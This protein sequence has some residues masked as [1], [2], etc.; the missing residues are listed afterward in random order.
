MVNNSILDEPIEEINVPVMK[1]IPYVAKVASLRNLTR[2]YVESLVRKS[3]ADVRKT[4]NKFADWI[5]SHVPERVRRN[6]N[7]RVEKLKK[8][9]KRI[10]SRYGEHTLYEREAPLRG[11]LRTYR[12]DGRRGYDQTTF[13]QYI[14]PRVIKLLSEKK[15]PFQVKFI[16]TFKFL[17]GEEYNES[18]FHTNVERIMEGTNI[19]DLYNIMIAMCLEKI[20]KFQNKGSGWQFDSVV[21]FDI[22]VDPFNPIRGSLYF[23]LPEKLARKHA[24]INVQNKQDN[25][26]FKWAVTS[27]V[28]QRKVHPE[29]FNQELIDNSKRLNWSGIDFPTPLNQIEIFEQQN[30]YSI[31]VYGYRNES[32]YTLRISKKHE[33]GKQ[34]IKLMLLE[35]RNNNHYCWIKDG[36]RLISSQVSKHNG[37]IYICDYCDNTFPTEESFER[38]IEYCSKHKAV[39]VNMPEKGTMLS[40]KNHQRKM[41]VPFVVYADFEALTKGISTCSPNDTSSYTKQYQKHTPCSFSYYIKCFD[42][43]L[44]P[45]QLRQYTIKER[46][47]NVGKIFVDNL[48]KDI[49]EIYCKFKFK[50]NMRITTEEE[51]DFQKATVCHICENLL[52]LDKVRDH[53]HLTGK[54][55]GAAHNQCNLNHVIPS[56]Y[57]VIFHNLSGYDTH[58]FIKDLAETPGDIKCIAKTEENYISFDKTLI[59]DTFMKNGKVIKVKRRIRFL[60][61]FRFMQKSLSELANN[62]TSN[63]NLQKHFDTDKLELVK[64][65]GVYP[66]D[67]MD[68]FERLSETSLPPIECW[69]SK[70]N[71]TNISTEEYIHAQ[72]VW[73][74]FGMKTMRDYHDLYLK[75][76]V[77]LLTDV[78]EEF[79]YLCSKH[80]GLDPAWYYTSPGLAWDA[81]LKM[82]KVE[83]ELLHDQDMLLLIEEA[84]RGG[85]SMISTRLGKANHKFMEEYDPSQP[86]KY[87]AY[88]DANNLYG[89]AMS[90]KLPTHGFKWMTPWQLVNW[91]YH[92][93]IVEVD[94]EYPHDLHDLHNDY[95]LAPE[96]LKMDGVDKL[97]PN[98]YNKSKY[99]VH[100]E[101]LKLYE[102]LGLVIT[103]VYKG[104]VFHDSNWM[105]SYIDINTKLRIQSKNN[106]EKDFFKLMNNSVFGKTIEDVRTRTDIKLV[107]TKEQA[108]KYI[109]K[110]NYVHRTT[111][112]DNLVAIHMEKTEIYMNKPVYLGMS[113]LDIS[114]TLMYEFHY[115]YIKPKYGD[116][117][118]LLFTDTD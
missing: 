94:L 73:D 5:I 57:P 86:S 64:R 115:N 80:Y 34:C 14:R 83:L 99:V 107:T 118:K 45:P 113:I 4:I 100:Y 24:I 26:C 8:D 51:Q 33:K 92:T 75:T 37:K 36:S 56:F 116:K 59:V 72:R 29:R 12:I 101:T 42:D 93:C 10:Y 21:S 52:L 28:F 31:N 54:Y 103:K 39:K 11:F 22:N 13:T 58:M 17:K 69:Y 1:P 44:F 95:P 82:T 6:A 109:Y 76:D 43:E 35:N 41:R 108:E 48:E 112:S 84:I 87:I 70:L 91:R 74:V 98:L 90:K 62:L 61:S 102:R 104:I 65:K 77:L 105:K 79:R 25:K 110:P 114:K 89:W 2:N 96:H 7:E 68:S 46:G 85:V 47:E 27:A 9:I 63:S 32:V 78:F 50:K 30:P 38:H 66:Y 19:G 3:A 18:Y 15:K 40:F 53:C 49:R 88:L 106:F 16:F 81:C 60:D 20:E 55:R 23:P 71:D 117:A 97:I 111:F 67:Y